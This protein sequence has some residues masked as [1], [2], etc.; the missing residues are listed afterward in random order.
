MVSGSWLVRGRIVV[1]F[2]WK[3]VIRMNE[4]MVALELVKIWLS[5]NVTKAKALNSGEWKENVSSLYREALEVIRA[6]ASQK[7]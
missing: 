6:S 1:Y 3:G 5:D 7:A 2:G 4:H